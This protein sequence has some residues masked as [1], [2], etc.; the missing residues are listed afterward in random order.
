MRRHVLVACAAVAFLATPALAD[1]CVLIQNGQAHQIW[2]NTRKAD[3]Q[4]RYAPGI[5][6]NIV[7]V[8]SGTVEQGHLWDGTSF[9]PPPAP[10]ARDVDREARD[11]PRH[12]RALVLFYLRD[13]LQRAPTV[14]ERQAAI[15]A[16]VQSY[17]DA[18]G[19]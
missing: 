5:V 6:A 11:I 12:V 8:P 19:P 17:K 14:A 1:D 10:P 18:A 15:E 4:T 13:K 3:L 16:L 7:E 9:S 2:R